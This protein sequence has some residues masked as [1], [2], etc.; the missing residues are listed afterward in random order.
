MTQML[1]IFTFSLIF[2]FV[3]FSCSE[4][5]SNEPVPNTPPKTF[6]SL[7]PGGD[8]SVTPSK[9][10]LHWWGVDVDGL[11]IG[12]VISFDSLHWHWTTSNDSLF[13]L[14][15]NRPDTSYKF[16]V[17]AIDNQGNGVYDSQTPYGP[18]PFTDLNNNGK[19]DPGEPFIDW[20]AIDSKPAMLKIPIQNSP[21]SVSFT[22]NSDVPDTTFPV[23]SFSWTGTDPDGNE[24]IVKYYWVLD[25]TLK[26]WKELT[27]TTNFLT[28]FKSNGL[29][30]GNHVFFLKALDIA[31][32]YSKIIRMP[33]EDKTWY[34]K[35]PISDFLIVDDY[36][37][38]DNSADFYKTFFDTLS[39]GRFKK[40]DLIDIK[41]G[42]TSISRAKYLPAFVNPTLTETF[43]LFKYI[44]WYSD[45]Q[46]N[47]DAAQRTLPDFKKAGGKVLFSAAFP[48]NVG[49]SQ[50]GIVDFA[51]IDGI[52]STSINIIPQ[53][54]N[55]LPDPQ[56]AIG[57]PILTRDQGLVPIVFIRS[58]IP[59]IDARVLY[60]FQSYPMWTGNPIIAVKDADIP[61]FILIGLPLHRFNGGSLKLGEFFVKVFSDFGFN[62]Y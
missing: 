29:A 32:A 21:P 52:S 18:E 2:S 59:K 41:L 36:G 60:S 22:I 26:S 8:L 33:G 12:F 54:V 7:F 20:G 56:N 39:N 40:R 47:L 25:D 37:T 4:R 46:P 49:E 13:T 27:G 6:I 45:N 9:Q 23:A 55:V 16:Y 17:A 24:T 62:G 50:G 11:V 51:P 34:I 1:R 14:Q 31:G 57:Y 61:S 42:L 53:N 3:F 44:Y 15:L 30:G 35:E 10:H 19:W 43:K 58:F 28:L 5:H 38:A 48:E